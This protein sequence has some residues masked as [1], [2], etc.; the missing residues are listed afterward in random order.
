MVDDK[1]SGLRKA[2]RIG[3]QVSTDE[4]RALL[5]AYD[6]LAKPGT[7]CPACGSDCN[8][9]DELEKAEREIERLCAAL[10][11]AKPDPKVPLL[12][13]FKAGKKILRSYKWAVDWTGQ[14]NVGWEECPNDGKG[15]WLNFD[16]YEYRIEEPAVQQV[17]PC[18]VCNA[19]I[20]TRNATHYDADDL[21]AAQ[22]QGR[23]V[24]KQVAALLDPPE[25]PAE[26]QR[27][28]DAA[29]VVMKQWAAKDDLALAIAMNELRRA[30]EG[31]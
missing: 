10:Q 12:D 13:A 7:S 14:A 15:L 31:K 29:G 18:S 28:R 8:E 21:K 4:I 5:D 11:Q 30:L 1:F 22:V 3:Y 24:A 19:L 17:E 27:L 6:A 25:P 26:V 9:R 2:V 23:I 16:L 20:V